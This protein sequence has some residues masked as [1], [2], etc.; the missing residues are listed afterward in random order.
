MDL[1]EKTKVRINTL[2]TIVNKFIDTYKTESP[3]IIFI[4]RSFESKFKQIENDIRHG[5]FDVDDYRNNIYE[6]DHI[7]NSWMT[8]LTLIV[9]S[10]NGSKNDIYSVLFAVLQGIDNLIDD[11]NEFSVNNVSED[12]ENKTSSTDE[13]FS[14]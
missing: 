12:D 3:D 1:H 10:V 13:G 5:V 14:D 4:I 7:M 2:L 8:N 6:F 9:D 11:D